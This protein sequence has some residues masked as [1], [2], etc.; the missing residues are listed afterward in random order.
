MNYLYYEEGAFFGKTRWKRG[1]FEAANGG[2]IFLDEIGELK[3][4]TAKIAFEQQEQEIVKSRWNKTDFI[5]AG[6][7]AATN[8]NLEKG[9]SKNTFIKMIYI[10]ELTGC[11]YIFHL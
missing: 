2:S 7:I 9:L 6:V 11:R 3:N 5:D 8:V 10:I 4:N 1:L